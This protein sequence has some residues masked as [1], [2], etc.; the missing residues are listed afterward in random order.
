LAEAVADSLGVTY[1]PTFA[2]RVLE[3]NGML[4]IPTYG[5]H[6]EEPQAVRPWTVEELADIV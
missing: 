5:V 1:D 3:A 2:E 4:D 6:D